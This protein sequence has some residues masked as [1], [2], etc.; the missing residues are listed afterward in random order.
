MPIHLLSTRHCTEWLVA[1]QPPLKHVLPTKLNK[2]KA[3]SMQLHLGQNSARKSDTNQWCILSI[4]KKSLFKKP[5]IH[6]YIYSFNC[7]WNCFIALHN[8]LKPEQVIQTKWK[9]WYKPTWWNIYI[10]VKIFL[11]KCACQNTNSFY[12]FKV[13]FYFSW[14]VLRK[15]KWI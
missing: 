10:Q 11:E 3:T 1:Q 14:D 4:S 6:T 12:V 8:I 9:G 15:Y 7:V 2:Q 13:K 5:Q